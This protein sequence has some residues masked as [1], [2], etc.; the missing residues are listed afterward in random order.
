MP[1]CYTHL[2]FSKIAHADA[3]VP[4]Y[5]YDTFKAGSNGPDVFYCYRVWTKNKPI[6]LFA[7][8]ETLHKEKCGE[9]LVSMIKNAKTDAQKGYVQGFL[10]HY[11]LDSFVHPYIEFIT[12][13]GQKYDF[14][15]GHGT[16]E[17]ALD[18][19]FF[20]QDYGNRAKPFKIM[21]PRL[22]TS[23]LADVTMVLKSAFYDIGETDILPDA[24][25]DSFHHCDALHKIFHS[26][27]GL[28]KLAYRVIENLFFGK[29]GLITVHVPNT[30]IKKDLPQEWVNPYDNK[31]YQGGVEQALIQGTQQSCHY[32]TQV[33]KYWDGNIT[34]DDIKLIIGNINCD[35]GQ[36]VSL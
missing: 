2:R 23:N 31:T 21:S 8:A 36:T 24:I 16:F 30:K 33:Q 3:K 11:A 13:N 19:L 18:T 14:K 34:L 29:N 9:F 1:E 32:L 10:C 28:K 7:I 6:D 20:Q 15:T 22:I 4:V 25:A 27:F 5:N 12:S 35:T 17:I 26:R